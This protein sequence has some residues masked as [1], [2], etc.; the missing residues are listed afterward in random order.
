MHHSRHLKFFPL[1]VTC[2]FALTTVASAQSYRVL[3]YFAG[4]DGMRPVA[5]LVQAGS[6]LYGTAAGGGAS[7]NATNGTNPGLGVVFKINTDGSGYSVLKSFAG[8]DGAGPVGRL[9]LAGS[10]LYGTTTGGGSSY[11]PAR[12][13]SGNG[14]V[15]KV[16][17]DGSGYTVLKNFTGTDGMKPGGTLVLVD[18]TLYGVTYYGGHLVTPTYA[19]CGVIFKVNADGSGYTV[20]KYFEGTDGAGP[21]G[22]L[23]LGGS[24]FYGGT[25]LGG[26]GF[27][28]PNEYGRG[29]IFRVN[30]D[31]SGYKVII[32]PDGNVYGDLVLA[33]GSALYGTTET[34]CGG[35]GTV[36]KVN[37]D[38]SGYTGLK[39]F[40]SDGRSPLAGLVLAGGTTLYGTTSSGERSTSV[41]GVVFK[42]N[43]DGSGYA[44]LKNFTGGDGANPDG[45]LLLAATTLYGTTAGGGTY[46][47]YSGNGCGVVFSLECLSIKVPP[48]TQT[49]EIGS[50]TRLQVQASSAAPGLAC[51]W[52]R[53]GTNA[54]AGETNAVL[55]LTD[56]QPA[57]AGAYTVMVTNM[58]LAL[59]SAPAILSVI[60]PTERRV[61]PAVRLTGASGS[62]FHAEFADNLAA[63]EWS[64]LADVSLGSESQFCF[65]LSQPLPGQR[66][67]RVSQ[68][69]TPQPALDLTFATA[70]R[71]TGAIGSSVR[72]DYINQLGPIDAWVTLATVIL[73]NTSEF[74]FDTATTGQ[75]PRLYRVVGVP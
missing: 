6:T 27:Y 72:V 67:Y 74:Y 68:T 3:K 43:T 15:F 22:G 63:P 13:D 75:P 33:G 10:T 31:G 66:F 25:V 49:A 51:Q 40:W 8:S 35:D 2:A 20:L 5:G 17:T 14:V 50:T 64:S 29:V 7:Y 1:S 53:D 54:L 16:N 73:T 4:T 70:I 30:T 55:E 36:F 60:A 38:G 45:A 56:V 9:L 58:G 23:V 57:Q 59:T 28:P 52:Y 47:P 32:Y 37:T 34:G 19:G 44:V 48:L 21:A 11:D 46:R 24:T 41:N 12:Y 42:V 65:D 62:S 26:N 69:N 61:V 71:L 39:C 18:S